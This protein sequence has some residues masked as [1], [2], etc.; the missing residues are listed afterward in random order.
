V[1]EPR[2]PG[3]PPALTG[4]LKEPRQEGVKGAG[5]GQELG[6]AV[7]VVEGNGDVLGVPGH[8]DH[9]WAAG[10]SPTAGGNPL[11]CAQKAP[12]NHPVCGKPHGRGMSLRRPPGLSPGPSHL[13]LALLQGRG[14]DA[15]GEVG[16]DEPAGG[17]VPQRAPE[18]DLL[19]PGRPLPVGDG[20]G[21][22]DVP[23]AEQ[24]RQDLL[25]PGGAWGGGCQGS[26]SPV[27]GTAWHGMA[28]HGM[29]QHGMALHG[30]ARHCMAWHGT[31]WHGTALHCMA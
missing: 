31:A 29:E 3:E 16:G 5:V 8:V 25:H 26:A 14:Q 20:L 12:G 30:A 27:W 10:V 15:G 28:Q 19:Q 1:A 6:Q 22:S 23:A 18:V 11:C 9:L 13:G 17:R 7:E 2:D 4:A 21:W 24:Q